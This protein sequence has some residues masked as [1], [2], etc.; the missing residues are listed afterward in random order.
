ML[1]SRSLAR[2]A[3][4]LWIGCGGLVL[5]AST[6]LPMGPRAERP[7]V[8]MLGTFA[9]AVGVTVW[10]LPWH[11]W[12]D[13]ATLALV[14]LAL[15][16]VAGFNRAADDPWLYSL[17]FMAAFVWVG[18]AHRQGVALLSAPLLVIA[19]LVPLIGRT[20]DPQAVAAL[21]YILPTCVILGEASAWVASRL[22][23][24]EAA[25][26]ASE[27]RY[28]AL[29]RHAA[30][31]VFVFDGDGQI[32]YVSPAVERVLGTTAADLI[33]DGAPALLHPDDLADASAW[34][35]SAL[36]GAIL[37]RPS[38]YR[39]RG[40]DGWRWMEGT[41]SDLRHD[42]HVAGVVVNGRDVTERIRA[43]QELAHLVDHDFLTGLAS[44]SAF[45]RQLERALADDAN[46]V[47]VLFLDLDGFKVVNDSLGH[48]VGDS[49]LIAVS[50]R[51]RRIVGA[52]EHVARLGGDEFTILVAGDDPTQASGLA[53]RIVTALREPIELDGRR[54][55]LTASIGV[56][57]TT[58]GVTE[59]AVALRHADLAMYRAKELGKDRF[60]VFG[61]ELERRVQRR[62]DVETELRMA[63]DRQ[64]LVVHYQP[65]FDAVGDRLVGMEALVRWEHP[66]R[67][68]VMPNDFIDVAEES[69][70]I[71]PLGASVLVQ[72]CATASRWRAEHGEHAPVV[73]VN[74]SARQLSDPTFPSLVAR[75]LA[76]AGL[77]P[78]RLR[79]E[80]TESL[81]VDAAAPTALGRLKAVGVELAID[82][83][84][85]GYS[86]LS[87]LD[88]LPVDVV[89]IDQCFL[90]P[91]DTTADRSPVIEATIVLARSFGLLVV[92][93]GVE[94]TDQREMLRRLGCDRLQGYLLGRP[95]DEATATALLRSRRGA[96]H[97]PGADPAGSARRR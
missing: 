40:F 30:D 10:Y 41:V 47:T 54:I 35:Q 4:A 95:V 5:T 83:F 48:A 42:P 53:Q 62:L 84:G 66:E 33:R 38:L 65:E 60:E 73:G 39:V 26:A 64:E 89:K 17:F 85:T 31:V 81:V 20:D 32:T 50:E 91:I 79:L 88:R 69:G 72:A 28:A 74:V 29:V 44:R 43:E 1:D 97:W 80:I 87:Y 86:S 16:V 61:D 11:R 13:R 58:P 45:L 77:P 52:S 23:R 51:L 8:L 70:L 56:A 22:R 71:G 2:V 24:A 59:P 3:A 68:L 46:A 25:T 15:V 75:V 57:T 90:T 37:D 19:Y 12:P 14:P 82:D 94:T 55:V 76:D 63:L 34:F 21:V 93:E 67:G 6:V 27:A 36:D 78:H 49:F 92:A 9:V 7:L 96:A 18:L